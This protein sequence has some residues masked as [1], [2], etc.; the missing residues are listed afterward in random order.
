MS[1]EQIYGHYQMPND[2]TKDSIYST[3]YTKQAYTRFK[4]QKTEMDKKCKSYI[5]YIIE[6]RK[7][8]VDKVLKNI[9]KGSV[10]LPVS[11]INIINN[12]Y[13]KNMKY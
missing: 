7:L 3:L 12:Q 8:I 4:K 6:S 2:K 10:N 11:F 1:I 13:Q 5:D 9:F